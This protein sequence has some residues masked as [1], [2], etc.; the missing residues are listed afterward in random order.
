MINYCKEY[1]W[2]QDSDGKKNPY[3]F[4]MPLKV[5]KLLK[6]VKTELSFNWL[7]KMPTAGKSPNIFQIVVN[8]VPL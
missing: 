5:S 8:H 7:F 6:S 1:Q 4:K 3:R 2:L